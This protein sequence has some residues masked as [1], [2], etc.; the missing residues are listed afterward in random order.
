MELVNSFRLFLM[1]LRHDEFL[2]VEFETANYFELYLVVYCTF[3]VGVEPHST[4]TPLFA[5]FV[6]KPVIV[7]SKQA[8]TDSGGEGN[9]VLEEVVPNIREHKSV[10]LQKRR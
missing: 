7:M 4:G 10:N 3:S 6:K 5:S 1:S 2:Q 8:S 9:G